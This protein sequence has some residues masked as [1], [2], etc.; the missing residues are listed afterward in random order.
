M[1][2]FDTPT[3]I[4][5][6]LDVQEGNVRITA[7]ERHDTV[8]EVH[9]TNPGDTSA[10]DAAEAARVGFTGTR[11]TIDV[12]APRHRGLLGKLR[13]GTT[14][15]A[16]DLPAGSHV[17]G[18]VTG[19]TRGIGRLGECHLHSGSGDIR[20]DETGPLHATTSSG[21]IEVDLA[22]GPTEVTTHDGEIHIRTV[23]GPA[24]IT[25]TNGETQIGEVTGALRL[26]DTNGEMSVD[27][28]L[29]NVDGRT[30]YGSI[31]IGEVFRGTVSLATAGG[32]LEVGIAHGT[33]AW[34]DIDTAG[35]ELHNELDAAPGPGESDETVDIR[36]RTG[37]GD[38][39]ICRS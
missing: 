19:E 22:V 8:V 35:G 39:R 18:S 20:L 14:D 30:A 23:D 33:A 9:P 11:L 16:I 4:S 21:E 32:E 38:I 15:V 29:G 5:V 10:A 12:C 37:G 2:A 27:R 34:L 25:N 13:T 1:P 31:R 28:A 6:V 17:R 7:S 36:A 26:T 3:P 24:T